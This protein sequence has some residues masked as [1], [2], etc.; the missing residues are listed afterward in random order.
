MAFLLMKGL[1]ALLI[2]AT[3][4]ITTKCRPYLMLEPA[5]VSLLIW[6]AFSI[7]FGLSEITTALYSQDTG[8]S[9]FLELKPPRAFQNLLRTFEEDNCGTQ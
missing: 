3:T 1:F 9:S 7:S 5:F 2:L 8:P 4:G 6:L